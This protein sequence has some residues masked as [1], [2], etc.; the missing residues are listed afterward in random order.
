MRVIDDKD[1]SK[2]QHALVLEDHGNFIEAEQVFSEL[3]KFRNQTQ[4]R[5]DRVVLFCQDKLT[6]I[7]RSCGRYKEAEDLSRTVLAE[8]KKKIS[9]GTDHD[10]TLH[11]AG[12]LAL[13]LKDQERYK[14]AIQLIR[15]IWGIKGGD[16]Y[17]DITRVRLVGILATLLHD[18][19]H[20]NL[21]LSL[22]LTRNVLSACEALLGPDDAFTLDQV[23]NLALLESKRGDHR[24]AEVINHR[25]LETLRK[26]L[27]PHHPLSLRITTRLG[28][29]LLLQERYEDAMTLFQGT[30]EVQETKLGSSHPDTW[31]TKWGLAFAYVFQGRLSDAKILLR[32]VLQRQEE[33]LSWDHP[34]I[35]RT[36]EALTYFENFEKALRRKDASQWLQ[37]FHDVRDDGNVRQSAQMPSI[38]ELV[39]TPLQAACFA[40]DEKTVNELLQSNV[41]INAQGGLFGT[42]LCAASFSG[43]QAIV[44]KLLDEGADPDAISKG[45]PAGSALRAAL[46]MNKQHICQILLEKKANPDI[47]DRWYGTP[48]H[49]ASMAGHAMI[50][51]LLLDHGAKPNLRGGIFGTALVA[52]AWQGK[53]KIVESLL[54][55]GAFLHGH[56]NGKTALYMATAER[57]DDI[58]KLLKFEAEA[59]RKLTNS[60]V[61]EVDQKDVGLPATN[62]VDRT[63]KPTLKRLRKGLAH[64]ARSTVYWP[65]YTNLMKTTRNI[66]ETAGKLFKNSRGKKRQR[67]RGKQ[68]I[69]SSYT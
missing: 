20:I 39:G 10:L 19:G 62:N 50:V 61:S 8:M 45:N 33:L 41:D 29:Y 23:S 67:Q 43:H 68:A 55:K 15:D 2:F 37:K 26:T 58:V 48:L 35:G 65:N 63:K 44:K 57:H 59:A 21:E 14:D 27:G 53:V 51:Q 36:K 32:Q 38:R 5:D 30:L 28:N 69:S 24:L 6:S 56:E 42:P 54:H 17:Q 64:G 13:I 22:F 4:D 18:F 34:A 12:N 9:L 52:A 60:L 47:T 31:S 49:E 66:K 7:W 3:S 11:C 1:R 25:S 40:G 16:P 46:M